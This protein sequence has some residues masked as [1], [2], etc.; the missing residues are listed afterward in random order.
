MVLLDNH[1]TAKG[2]YYFAPPF[3][4][5]VQGARINHNNITPV[6]FHITKMNYVII[7][8]SEKSEKKKLIT[9][10]G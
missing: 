2:S 1:V 5:E 8:T 4:A 9:Q 3:C 10:M 6:K 7:W